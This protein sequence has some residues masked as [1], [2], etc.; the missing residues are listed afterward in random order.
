MLA[1][2]IFPFHGPMSTFPGIFDEDALAAVKDA[3][4]V[5]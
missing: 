4:R 2:S 5:R 1:F 3:F